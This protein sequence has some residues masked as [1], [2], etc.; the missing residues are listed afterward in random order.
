MKK[1]LIGLLI[2]ILAVGVVYIIIP[3]TIRISKV[4]VLGV[5]KAGLYR[6][7]LDE[8]NWNSWWPVQ[9]DKSKPGFT[10]NGNSYSIIKK[11]ITSF[12]IDVKNG[13]NSLKSSFTLIPLRLDSTKIQ[14]DAVMVTSIN[15]IKRVQAYLFSNKLKKDL[16][17]IFGKISSHYSKVENV[18]GFNI[19]NES[20]VDSLLVFISENSKTYPGTE[21]IYELI[22][23]LKKYIAGK[24]A[25]ETGYPM[26]N[27]TT[28]DSINWITKVAIPT[29]RL[30]DPSG[31]I[32]YRKM[33]GRGNILVAEVKGGPFAIATAF[34]QLENYVNDYNRIAPAIPFQSLVTNRREEPD[35]SKWITRIYYP[36]M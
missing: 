31:N 9:D 25:K 22:N 26:L 28:E 29:D 10:Y 27:I 16:D 5:P 18:Y 36:V 30:L 11:T 1:W 35:T 33:L 14:L 7:M 21:S 8:N 24:G 15:P 2:F 4:A 13:K 20:V 32:T 3:G 34:G 23:V 17:V 12:L 19:K 6:A